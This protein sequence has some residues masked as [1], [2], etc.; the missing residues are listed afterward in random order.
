LR[1]NQS[2]EFM[3][4][5]IM[6]VAGSGKTTVGKRLASELGWTFYDADD[7]HPRANVEKMSRGL[8]LT[9]ED[10]EPWLD[11]LRALTD[12]AVARREN[13]VLACSALKQRYRDRLLGGVPEGRLV[14]LEGD[15]DTLRARLERRTDHYM[16]SRMLESQ[17]AA[18][19]P[20]AGGGTLIVSAALPLESIVASI[21]RALEL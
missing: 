4:I 9:D 16:K 19:E 17:L 13:V 12:A 7:Y 10:R 20:P 2:D 14:Y 15:V 1:K 6:G 3:I 18:L 11:A 5:L 21:R 8:P